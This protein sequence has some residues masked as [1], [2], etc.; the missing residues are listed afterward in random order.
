MHCLWQNQ[1]KTGATP[2]QH[3]LAASSEGNREYKVRQ[4]AR[5]VDI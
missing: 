3:Y 1:A 5:L 4:T 2:V